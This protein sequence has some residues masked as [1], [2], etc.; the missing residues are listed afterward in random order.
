MDTLL[1]LQCI[2]FSLEQLGISLVL[3]DGPDSGRSS[4]HFQQIIR[5]KRQNVS[6]FTSVLTSAD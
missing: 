2:A 5:E 1:Y 6:L 3:L 4:P